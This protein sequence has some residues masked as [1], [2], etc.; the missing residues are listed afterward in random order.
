MQTRSLKFF[1]LLLLSMAGCQKGQ[2]TGIVISVDTCVENLTI[3]V[4]GETRY[5]PGSNG[6]SD[7]LVLDD[8]F[9]ETGDIFEKDQIDVS[10]EKEN[11]WF[12]SKTLIWDPNLFTSL[13]EITDGTETVGWA[14]PFSWD[15]D[16]WGNGTPP[17]EGD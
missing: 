13:T 10:L 8:E 7:C 5:S 6:F 15:D 11:F 17:T 4:N 2:P 1:L 14:V 9:F 12:E 16:E 3:S